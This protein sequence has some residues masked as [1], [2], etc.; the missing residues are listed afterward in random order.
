V[1]AKDPPYLVLDFG[2][3]I[4]GRLVVKSKQ[5]ALAE[6]SIGESLE[7]T[8]HSPWKTFHVISTPSGESTTD[9]SAFRFAKIVFKKMKGQSSRVE[10]TQIGAE[11]IEYL[12]ATQGSFK[13][14]DPRLTQIWDTGAYTAHLCMQDEIWDA[15]K[16][17][18]VAWMGDLHVSGEVINTVFAD[19]L[20]M[21]KTLRKL[22]ED[23]QGGRPLEGSPLN[24][25]NKIPGYSCAW[26]A[27]LADF[28]RHVGDME[29]LKQQKLALISLLDYLRGELDSRGVFANL[30][31]QSNFVDWSPGSPIKGLDALRATHFFLAYAVQ[32]ASFL[33]RELNDDVRAQESLTWTNEL[34]ETARN[35]LLDKKTNTYG[36][37][38]Q[39]NAMAVLAGVPTTEQMKIIY[40]KVLDPA[41]PS[42]KQV[43]T[44]YYNFYVLEAMSALGHSP[45]G[46]DFV[47]N[48]WGGMLDQGATTFWEAYDPSWPKENFHSHLQADEEMGTMISLAHGWSSGPTAWLSETVLGV[49]P[50]SGGF[51]DVEIRPE[52][53]DLEWAEGQVPTPQGNLSVRLDRDKITQ[54]IK[55]RLTLPSGIH[56][57]V[58]LQN[59]PRA[60]LTG[61]GDFEF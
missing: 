27:A 23:A 40:E 55:M 19:R 8:L 12:V 39:V 25:I 22:R 54:N 5:T 17:D 24:H 56:A 16:R 34:R 1:D 11:R 57:K 58:Y 28:H 60:D 38:R 7:E 53:G 2:K 21:E 44:P 35:Y 50:T 46:M 42:W 6:I 61:P 14:S 10:Y 9:S 32:E 18:R 49:K 13:C 3:E 26:I 15:P 31:K 43:A 33:F 48:Y 20:L 4:A 52:L 36:K 51:R 37:R 59:S 29:F 45:V 41:S 30:R 47:R